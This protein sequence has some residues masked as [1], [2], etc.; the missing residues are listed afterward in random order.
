[1]ARV[2]GFYR[3]ADYSAGVNPSDRLVIAEADNTL[4]GSCRLCDEQGVLVL[5]GMRVKQEAQRQGIGTEML[6]SAEKIMAGRACYCIPY[7]YLSSFYAHVG[8]KEIAPHQ[9]PEFLRHRLK[10]YRQTLRLDVI[11]MWR[12]HGSLAAAPESGAR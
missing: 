6:R 9:A 7:R 3:E 5:R 11:I 2:E 12:D 4:L 8:F 1:M 10:Q